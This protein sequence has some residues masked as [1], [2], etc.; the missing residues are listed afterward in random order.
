MALIQAKLRVDARVV[1]VSSSNR[2]LGQLAAF[3]TKIGFSRCAFIVIL[4][5]YVRT[6]YW[7]AVGGLAITGALM[8]WEGYRSTVTE[9]ETQVRELKADITR[10]ANQL[11]VKLRG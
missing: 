3:L 4:G 11:G 10:V 2:Y 9:L 5:I 8:A 7:S 1:L 6:G